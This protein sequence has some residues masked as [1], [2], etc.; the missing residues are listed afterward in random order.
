MVAA[1]RDDGNNTRSIVGRL[2]G[3]SGSNVNDKT[4]EAGAPWGRG[5][6]SPSR[7]AIEC[8]V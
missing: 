4:G 7:G 5:G 8:L 3:V 1:R 6:A 2:L